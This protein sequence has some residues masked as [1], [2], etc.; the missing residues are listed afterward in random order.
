M[1][2]EHCVAVSMYQD[3]DADTKPVNARV[4]GL[5]RACGLKPPAVIRGNAVLSRL[6]LNKLMPC[7]RGV[8]F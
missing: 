5:M 3:G 1:K 8:Q 2:S 7:C 6:V 4:M